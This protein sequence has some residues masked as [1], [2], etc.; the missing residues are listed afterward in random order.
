MKQDRQDHL[1]LSKSGLIELYDKLSD[2][3]KY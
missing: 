2:D 1:E 3:S